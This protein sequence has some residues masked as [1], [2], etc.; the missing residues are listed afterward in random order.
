[1]EHRRYKEERKKLTIC[2]WKTERKEGGRGNEERK[3]VEGVKANKDIMTPS[4]SIWIYIFKYFELFK[5]PFAWFRAILF[6]TKY[7]GKCM[8]G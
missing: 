1:M 8:D 6:E 4:E 7:T 3:E 5:W 2:G